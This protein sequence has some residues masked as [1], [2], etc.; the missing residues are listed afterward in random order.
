M[1]QDVARQLLPKIPWPRAYEM[2]AAQCLF[3]GPNATVE[4]AK[5]DRSSQLLSS[6]LNIVRPESSRSARTENIA[7]Q[8]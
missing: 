3:V 2:L 6:D 8:K 4:F 5:N 7:M 1:L